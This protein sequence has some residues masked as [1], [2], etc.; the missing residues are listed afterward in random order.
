MSSQGGFLSKE[1]T[2]VNDFTLLII[3][4]SELEAAVVE[5][6]ISTRGAASFSTLDSSRGE[7]DVVSVPAG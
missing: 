4:D 6:A 1:Q 5:S 7:D 2:I 3:C